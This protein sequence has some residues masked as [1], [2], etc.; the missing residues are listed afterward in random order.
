MK[1]KDLAVARL[2]LEFAGLNGSAQRQFMDRVNEY[3][4]ASRSTRKQ[5]ECDWENV[6]FVSKQSEHTEHPHA[7]EYGAQ[8]GAALDG[9]PADNWS[10]RR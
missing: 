10:D 6:F 1:K 2:L 3:L 4:F 9:E 8:R 5:L 7:S